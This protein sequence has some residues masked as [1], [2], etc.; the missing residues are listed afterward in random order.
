MVVSDQGTEFT[1]NA[2]LDWQVQHEA[3]WQPHRARQTDAERLRR[4]L[5]GMMRVECFNEDRV[6][7]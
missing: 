6:P 7:I 1:S 2:I 4:V 5:H 3:E